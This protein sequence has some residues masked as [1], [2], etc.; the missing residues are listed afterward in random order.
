MPSKITKR[1]KIIKKKKS[2]R[3]SRVGGAAPPP[4]W[5]GITPYPQGISGLMHGADAPNPLLLN[6]VQLLTKTATKIRQVE[7]DV[8]DSIALIVKGGKFP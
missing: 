5:N 8:A 7:D 1:R 4:G 6:A 3:Y 2:N